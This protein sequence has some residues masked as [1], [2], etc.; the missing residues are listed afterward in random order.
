MKSFFQLH[1]EDANAPY[2]SDCLTHDVV[3]SADDDWFDMEEFENE[4][5]EIKSQMDRY[6]ET[7]NTLYDE[8]GDYGWDEKIEESI[9][10]VG[11]NHP[12]WK[13]K[14]IEVESH[15]IEIN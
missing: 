8:Y 12:E 9:K 11:K 7:D 10:I 6:D 2:P 5:E 4:V 13:L 15:T 14:V 1:F 3:I